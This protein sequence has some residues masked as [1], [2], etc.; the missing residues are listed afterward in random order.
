MVKE[1]RSC[2]S[3]SHHTLH[4]GEQRTKISLST[5]APEGFETGCGHGPGWYV[6]RLSAR[7]AQAGAEHP[8]SSLADVLAAAITMVRDD[9]GGGRKAMFAR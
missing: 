9:H 3:V 6:R 7:L 1:S 2:T 8:T 5:T 4:R